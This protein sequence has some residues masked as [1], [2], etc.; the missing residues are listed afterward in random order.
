MGVIEL[1]F[2]KKIGI[3]VSDRLQESFNDI[4]DYNFTANFEDRLDKIAS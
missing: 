2:V 1:F 4:M 3:I